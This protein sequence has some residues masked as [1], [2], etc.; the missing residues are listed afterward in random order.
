MLI[1]QCLHPKK[2]LFVKA[3]V[4]EAI[5]HSFVADLFLPFLFKFFI[6][7][8]LLRG[9][10]ANISGSLDETD[11]VSNNIIYLFPELI[12]LQLPNNRSELFDHELHLE[13][14]LFIRSLLLRARFFSFSVF[15]SFG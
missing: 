12:F 7:D 5:V 4:Y 8:Q 11:H 10:I 3:P 14:I 13:A 6:K 2:V 15:I 1:S 9:N